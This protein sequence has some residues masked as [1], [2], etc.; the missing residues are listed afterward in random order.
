[1]DD[2]TLVEACL[3]QHPPAMRTMVERFQPTVLGLCCRMLRHSHDAEDVTQEVFVRVFRSLASWDA[4]RPL[5]PWVVSIAVNRCRT[6]LSRRGTRPEPVDFLHETLGREDVPDSSELTNEIQTALEA[7]RE[8]YRLVFAMFHERGLSLEEVAAAMG[9]PSG[10][11]K[12]WLHRTRAEL[13]D[14]LRRRG[15]VE[16]P[17]ND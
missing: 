15:M 8:D 6:W 9:R 7:M 11:I 2:A 4:S 13:L 14:H 1:M 5:R 3:K 10:T 17:S 16:T 12:T